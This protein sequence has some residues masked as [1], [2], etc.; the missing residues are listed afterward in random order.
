[1][2]LES[3]VIAHQHGAMNTF[4]GLVLTAR[5]TTKVGNARRLRKGTKVGSVI[6][7]KS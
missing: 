1:M 6:R 2:K 3:L 5:H 7:V 4:S